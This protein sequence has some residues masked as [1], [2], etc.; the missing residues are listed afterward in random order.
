MDDLPNTSG[1]EQ[2]VRTRDD[3]ASRPLV[4][5]L[6]EALVS[7]NSKRASGGFF[8]W[9]IERSRYRGGGRSER[10]IGGME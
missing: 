5:D 2:S 9:G 1:A 4:V 6:D 3:R 7:S 10:V 8:R